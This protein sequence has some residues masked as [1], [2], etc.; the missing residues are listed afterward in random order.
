[1]HCCILVVGTGLHIAAHTG[2][3]R[4][5]AAAFDMYSD[6]TEM[7]ASDGAVEMVAMLLMPAMRSIEPARE[8]AMAD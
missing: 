1:M 8:Q 2:R 7:V 6:E 5:R 4:W 3:L